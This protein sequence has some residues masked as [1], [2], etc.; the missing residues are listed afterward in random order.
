MFPLSRSKTLL[1]LLIKERVW[2]SSVLSVC[3]ITIHDML[4]RQLAADSPPADLRLRLEHV[5]KLG[6]PGQPDRFFTL[7]TIWTDAEGVRIQGV[8]HKKFAALLQTRISVGSVYD[9]SNYSFRSP[10]PTLRTCRYP[11][12]LD[13]TPSTK[14]TL[15]PSGDPFNS[16]NFELIPFSKFPG[17]LP[18]C[19]YLTDFVGKLISVGKP[20]YVEFGSSVA[21]VQTLRLLMSGMRLPYYDSTHELHLSGFLALTYV[22]ASS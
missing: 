1:Y 20:N 11:R 7:G 8:T 14:F 15:H 16:E 13:L 6:N 5:W 3:A 22:P 9:I 10:R 18:S 21:P 12:W 19:A 17:R 2:L 4:L